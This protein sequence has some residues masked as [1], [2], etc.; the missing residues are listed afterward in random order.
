M[1]ETVKSMKPSVQDN[2]YAQSTADSRFLESGSERCPLP[3]VPRN[4]DQNNDAKHDDEGER[5]VGDET[6]YGFPNSSAL[7]ELIGAPTG[8]AM[9]DNKSEFESTQSDMPG[10]C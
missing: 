4:K 2:G 1:D 9:A 7:R 10:P 3:E 6:N 8:T 5:Q